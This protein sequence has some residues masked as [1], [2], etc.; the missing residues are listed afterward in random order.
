MLAT[1]PV[2]SW[3]VL[4]ILRGI[5]SSP[6]LIQRLSGNCYA[7]SWPLDYQ[8]E[9][10]VP[11]FVVL[12]YVL[13]YACLNGIYVHLEYRGVEPESE[14]MPPFRAPFIHPS[15][16]GLGPIHVPDKASSTVWK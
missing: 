8:R 11:T 5:D 10:I 7:S 4:P 9:Y 13:H 12:F 16:S 3:Y 1:A 14:A 15:T 6:R 2:E